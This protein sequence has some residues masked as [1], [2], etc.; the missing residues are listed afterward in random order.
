MRDSEGNGL[1]VRVTPNGA[2]AFLFEQSLKNQTIRRTIG[3]VDTLTVVE[4]RAEARRLAGLVDDGTDPRELEREQA[5]AKAATATER[6]AQE[7]AAAVER[8]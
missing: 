2:K 1:R 6:A 3:S 7:A 4:A 5:E 8:A